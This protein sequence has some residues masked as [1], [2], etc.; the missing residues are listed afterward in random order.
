MLNRIEGTFEMQ[1]RFTA[2]A[3]HELMSPLSRLRAELEITLR[4]PRTSAEYEEA[5]RSCLEEVERLSALTEELLGLVRLDTGEGRGPVAGPALVQPI[6]QTVMQRL[7]GEAQRRHVTMEIESASAVSVKASPGV[8]S[9]ALANVLE[10]AVKFCW[11][12]RSGHR[13]GRCGT[14]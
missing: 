11:H 7:E 12:G 1:R 14:G 10:N 5:L 6:L 2:D 13:A 8:V 3:S 4:R 9:V